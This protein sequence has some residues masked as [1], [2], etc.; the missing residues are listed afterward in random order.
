VVCTY[1][2]ARTLDQCLEGLLQLD[3]PSFEIIVV[4]D[5]STDRTAAIARSRGVRVIET[6]NRGLS[7]ARNT[8]VNAADGEIVAFIDD[9]AF[10]DPHWLTYLAAA[11]LTTDFVGI[12]GPNL[13]VPG[14]GIVAQCVANAP[15]GPAH[16]LLTDRE[17][18]HIPGCNMAFRKSALEAIGGFDPRYRIAGDDVDVC[19]RVQE[20]EGK[21]GFTAA[22]VVWHHR[23]TSVRAFCRQQFQY[24]KAEGIL[25]TKWPAKYNGAG[26]ATWGGRLYGGLARVAERTWGARIY[27]GTWGSASY[28]S[29]YT[30]AG[31]VWSLLLMPEWYL[32]IACFVASALVG[33]LWRP[34]FW[35]LL[36]ASMA[37]A[38]TIGLAVRSAASTRFEGD[39]RRLR[40]LQLR[41]LT[42]LL[43]LLQPAAR[44]AGRLACGLTPWRGCG[45]SLRIPRP[46]SVT[47][48]S[49]RWHAAET[50][51]SS[52]E[53]RLRGNG[54]SVRLGGGFDR[55]DLEVRTGMLGTARL[56]MAIEEHGAGRQLVRFQI[57][58][59]VTLPVVAFAIVLA[60][61]SSEALRAGA[62]V[63]A[64][65]FAAAAG[66]IAWMV[67]RG[68]GAAVARLEQAMADGPLDEVHSG[69]CAASFAHEL[70][71]DA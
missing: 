3:Y 43:I 7:S 8:G 42:T 24:G 27:H 44:L 49:E 69:G 54:G 21:L 63:A 60:A 23:R 20:R 38:G 28:Q 19:W 17:A 32:L 55:W 40:L 18:E 52:V 57:W 15:G 39:H 34:V 37:A 5:G 26:H 45:G 51:L 65:I 56:R 13:P 9:D 64:T 22:A 70:Q 10:P 16:V 1:N 47:V 46:R 12:G 25:E 30:P 33:A 58:P 6:E 29:M 66:L 61:T 4:S 14:S 11:F 53:R 67:V 50:W 48:W 59:T 36:P 41:A 31:P 62:F 2:G 68:C 71:H 35:C